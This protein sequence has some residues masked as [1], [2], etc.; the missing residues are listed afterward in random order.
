MKRIRVLVVCFAA[1]SILPM[2]T[3]RL[4]QSSATSGRTIFLKMLMP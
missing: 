1:G 3:E 2:A 4:R